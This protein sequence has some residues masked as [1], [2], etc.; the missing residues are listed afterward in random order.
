M[1]L[2]RN[3]TLILLG[4][5]GAGAAAL[6]AR[7]ACP[8]PPIAPIER[9][10]IA[11]YLG[12]WYEIARFPNRFEKACAGAVTAHYEQRPDGTLTVLNRCR[13]ADG[14]IDEAEGQA[15]LVGP[16]DAATL[17]VRFAPSW[18]SF[19]PAVWG[20]YWV[21]DLDADYTLA[22]VSEP[23]GEYL[24]ILSRTP[25]VDAARLDALIGRLQRQG[26]DVA[27]LRMTPQG[28]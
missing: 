16:A 23:R 20:D 18:L 5:A 14:R 15:R 26:L 17:K 19:L 11:R 25:R 28:S 1:R 24:W 6:A 13:D 2:T 8:R 10:D 22:A 7:R 21:I 27:R 4:L 9:L 12:D 3:Q